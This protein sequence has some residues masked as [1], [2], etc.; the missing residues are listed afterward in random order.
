MNTR[1]TELTIEGKKIGRAISPAGVIVEYEVTD[2]IVDIVGPQK[3][4]KLVL[5]KICFKDGREQVRLGYYVL[6]QKG[7][8]DGRWVWG[9]NA[10]FLDFTEFQNIIQQAQS[11]GW[12]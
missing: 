10:P 6:G 3:R 7:D 9:R 12:I 8:M 2:E 5:Q 11:K 4:K 1:K